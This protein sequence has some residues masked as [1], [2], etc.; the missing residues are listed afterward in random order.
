[1]PWIASASSNFG[2]AMTMKMY[3]P[4]SAMTGRR[5]AALLL[6]LQ[7]L[8]LDLLL[9]ELKLLRLQLLIRRRAGRLLQLQPMQL[10]LLLVE[11]ELHLAQLF[12]RRRRLGERR[13]GDRHRHQG[14]KPLHVL[15]LIIPPR[16]CQVAPAEVSGRRRAIL[17][18]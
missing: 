3:R 2:L 16:R 15:D 6:L 7:P 4:V 9:L 17:L 12:L 18:S 10:S 8:Q 1:M 11:L 13:R 5:R 14:I